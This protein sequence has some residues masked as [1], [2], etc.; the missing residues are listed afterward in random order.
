VTSGE[1]RTHSSTLSDSTLSELKDDRSSGAFPV[2]G[3]TQN[4]LYGSGSQSMSPNPGAR[5]A[6]RNGLCERGKTMGM[7]E[8]ER[9]ANTEEKA[10]VSEAPKMEILFTNTV[11]V[12]LKRLL[13]T[14]SSASAGSRPTMETVSFNALAACVD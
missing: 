10:G 4:T 5:W 12:A 11:A 8:E 2:A 1:K 7:T 13:T 9:K 14:G 3:K 6:R